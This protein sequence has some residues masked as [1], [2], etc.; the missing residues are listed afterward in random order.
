MHLLNG[1][2]NARLHSEKYV[3]KHL[4]RVWPTYV[5][6]S[7]LVRGT[8]S[9]LPDANNLESR[10]YILAAYIISY[11]KEIPQLRKTEKTEMSDGEVCEL[12]ARAVVG[13]EDDPS[14][15]PKDE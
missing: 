13:H 9:M 4:V 7:K 15:A 5:K 3:W 12:Y 10:A 14:A 8:M 11:D 1:R 6:Y 2:Q